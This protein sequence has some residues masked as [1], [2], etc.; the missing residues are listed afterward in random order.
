M[1][2]PAWPFKF[3]GSG[4]PKGSANRKVPDIV[5]SVGLTSMISLVHP[6]PSAKCGNT[7]AAVE[8]EELRSATGSVVIRNSERSFTK[9]RSATTETGVEELNENE[10]VNVEAPLKGASSKNAA[11]WP[12]A[13]MFV[14][15]DPTSLPLASVKK[16]DTAA[17][18]LFGFAIA[19]PVL[20]MLVA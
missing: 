12:L 10:P 1:M 9:P 7:V 18:S 15:P 14:E 20:T 11:I 13:G 17:A 3:T 6:P 4:L 8:V 5:L 2:I 16:K 19:R